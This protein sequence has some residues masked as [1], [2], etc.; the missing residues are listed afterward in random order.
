M[1]YFLQGDTLLLPEDTDD[2]D[3]DKD[4][5]LGMSRFF[6]GCEIFD[7]PV[8]NETKPAFIQTVSVLPNTQLPAGW[9][10]IPVRQIVTISAAK[11]KIPVYEKLG[12][13]L[14]ACHIVQ[15]MNESRFCGSCGKENI[16]IEEPAHRLCSSCGRLE[17]P[18]ICPAIIAIITDNENR[19]LLAHNKRFKNRVYSHISGFNEAGESLEE[20]VAREIREEVNI[21]VKNISYIKSQSWP[22][23]N[24]LMLGFKALYLS[25]DIQPDGIEIED[26][27]WFTRE[28]LPELPG[29]GS[30]SRFLINEWLSGTL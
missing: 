8:I 27:K 28:E 29:E 24:S 18:R 5:P 7:I 26:V 1:A 21:E 11:K 14:R 15:W 16:Y 2:F 30:L 12:R 10:K 17:F 3:F 9:K 4:L 22:F 20:T 13:I 19:I 23:P 6:A 25:G